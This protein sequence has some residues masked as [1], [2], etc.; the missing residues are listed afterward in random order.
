MYLAPLNYD[1]FFKKVFSELHIAQR[2]LEDFFDIEIE[3]IESLPTKHKITDNATAVEFDFRCKVKGSYIIID[4]Q[5]WFKT[6]IIKRF[7]AYHSLNTVL[8][9]EKIPDKSLPVEDKKHNEIKDYESILPVLTLIWLADDSLG[10]SDDFVSYTMTSE[11]V[12]DF[13]KNKNIW[14]EDNILEILQER[15]RCL[16]ILSNSTKKLDFL[17]ENKLI[18]AFQQNIVKNKKLTK[19]LQWFEFAEKTSD[20]RNEKSWFEEYM[21]DDVFVEIV[22]RINTDSFITPDWQYIEDYDKYAEQLERYKNSVR[23]DAKTE[24]AFS[25]AINMKNL[26]IA[27]DI[28]AQATGLTIK[29][30]ENL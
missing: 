23:K 21:K 12:N 3:E 20:K 22:S 4:M 2:F 15:E 25:I 24:M 19:Y 6:D 10:F 5:Q 11:T 1:R 27:H 18:Y 26:G 30:I 8:Q 28:I 17:Q 14:R 9:L 16:K 7:Y 13:I 29:A